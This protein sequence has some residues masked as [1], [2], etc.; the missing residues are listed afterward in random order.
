VNSEHARFSS[1]KIYGAIAKF[2]VEPGEIAQR[3]LLVL[4]DGGSELEI[5]GR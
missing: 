5:S 2:M 3:P 4:E 1:C